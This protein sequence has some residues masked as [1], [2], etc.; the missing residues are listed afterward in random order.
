[1][2]PPPPKV[3]L[4]NLMRVLGESAVANPSRIESQVKDQVLSRLRAHQERNESRRLD[5]ESRRKK[6]ISKWTQ[7][8]GEMLSLSC[9]AEVCIFSVVDLSDK[10]YLYKVCI[11]VLNFSVA[12]ILALI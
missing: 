5:V 12:L 10:K 3:K 4:A 9:G 6:T 8:S 1:M 2:P 7:P 11:S